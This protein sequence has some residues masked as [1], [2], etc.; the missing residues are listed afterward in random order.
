MEN[1][2]SFEKSRLGGLGNY[3][4]SCPHATV[5]EHV[6]TFLQ[7]AKKKQLEPLPIIVIELLY[8][9]LKENVLQYIQYAYM[10]VNRWFYNRHLSS[11]TLSDEVNDY[12]THKLM[13][14]DMYILVLGGPQYW[15]MGEGISFEKSRLAGL[16]NYLQS[17]PH[18]TVVEHVKTFVQ[19]AKKKQL[20]PLPIIVI[21]LLYHALKENVLR[22][23]EYAYM[24][25]NRWF[26]NQHLRPDTLPDEVN[27]Y[28]THKLM[29]IDMYILVLGGP[30]YWMHEIKESCKASFFHELLNTQ[31]ASTEHIERWL[32]G[33]V[34]HLQ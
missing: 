14:I 1:I 30:Q 4:Q 29:C 33:Y 21:E 3:L 24:Y 19:Y 20:E 17:C 32:Q 10:Y 27:D 28:N 23:I 15:I 5:V 8:H 9:A 16:G 25:V 13:C 11:V 34:T 18:A 2:I 12:N 7:Y 31:F 6:R 26:Y 22:Y